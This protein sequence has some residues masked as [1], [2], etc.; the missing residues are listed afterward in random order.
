METI[1][2][3]YLYWVADCLA[4]ARHRSKK[5]SS[6]STHLNNV[7]FIEYASDTNDDGRYKIE[8][9]MVVHGVPYLLKLQ[10]VKESI[11]VKIISI[12]LIT[13]DSY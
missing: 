1:S 8:G 13:A 3:S 9:D 5:S 10:Q 4:L 12:S 6:P 7:G 11:R 2:K